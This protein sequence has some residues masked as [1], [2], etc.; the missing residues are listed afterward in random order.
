MREFVS[1]YL[2]GD[3]V[4][5]M[6]IILFTI[7]SL[8]AVY[9]ATG[10]LAYRYQ[11]GNTLYYFMRHGSFLLISLLMVYVTH[12]I[13]YKVY[14]RLSQIFLLAVIVLLILTLITGVR[15]NEASRWLVVPGVG[16]TIQ[17]SDLAKLALIMYLARMLSI[18]QDV[19][20]DLKLSFVPLL[21]PIVLVCL[22]ILPA[23]FS[24]AAMLFIVSMTLLFIGR[25]NFKY[26]SILMFSGLFTLVI[27]IM[28]VL[29]NDNRGSRL[30]TWKHRIEAFTGQ[31]GDNY[32]VEQSKMAVIN[33]GFFGKGPGKSTQRNYLPHPYSDFIYAI[34]IE[35]Y[36]FFGGFIVLMLYLYLL[37]RAGL[38][39]EKCNRT[40]PAFLTIGLALMLV[41]QALINMGVAVNLLP[42]TGQPLPFLSMGG[43]SMIFTSLAL[44]IILS[45]SREI[46]KEEVVLNT[47]TNPLT[48]ENQETE[49]DE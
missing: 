15:L 7:I 21:V 47:V 8:L 11:H 22:L 19:I 20:K 32:Q 3:K 46:N 9:S 24:T 29:N 12:L 13:P 10:S 28:V 17:T 23:N 37:Y 30:Y 35:E 16:L 18:K 5:W 42:V 49:A 14:A 1:T 34:I 40:F 25:V 36:G 38:I 2:K 6:I 44:G 31:G 45:I 27:F 41:F 43:T 39:V 4:I 33:G 26:L 48:D